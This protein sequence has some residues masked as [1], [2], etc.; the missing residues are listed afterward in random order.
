MENE[1]LEDADVRDERA[2][3]ELGG[4][5]Q[6][7]LSLGSLDHLPQIFEDVVSRS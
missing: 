5:L 1:L 4:W 7:W 3:W 6:S 2:E